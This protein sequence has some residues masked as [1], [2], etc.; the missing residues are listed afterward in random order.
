MWGVQASSI[1]LWCDR[2]SAMAARA[3][4]SA[5]CVSG[6]RRP[7]MDCNCVA[8]SIASSAMDR[9]TISRWS[10]V[11]HFAWL[12]LLSFPFLM[13]ISLHG[14]GQMSRGNNILF[15][16]AMRYR[17]GY[18]YDSPYAWDMYHAYRMGDHP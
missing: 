7:R 10:R 9:S 6:C 1:A 3:A 2:L 5:F 13:K 14:Y 4:R 16:N 12:I 18:A 15:Y 8:L 11:A 17:V